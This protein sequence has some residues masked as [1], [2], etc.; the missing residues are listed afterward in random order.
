MLFLISR[1]RPAARPSGKRA[2]V[3]RV[4]PLSGKQDNGFSQDSNKKLEQSESLYRLP[5]CLIE[6]D[7]FLTDG[8]ETLNRPGLVDHYISCNENTMK[9]F[10]KGYVRV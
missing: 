1:G 6:K 10:A 7:V 8:G 2:K 4:E 9:K 5:S 3:R